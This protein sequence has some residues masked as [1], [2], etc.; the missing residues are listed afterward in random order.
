MASERLHVVPHDGNWAIK[1]ENKTSPEST[2]STQRDAI[3]AARELCKKDQAD[4]VIHRP[5]GTIRNVYSYTETSTSNMYDEEHAAGGTTT[6]RRDRPELNDLASVGS[7]ISWGAVMAGAF[8]AL[9]LLVALG[10][11]ATAAGLSVRDAVSDG[12]LF[13]GAMIC[14]IFALVAALFFG[15]FM[16]S[17]LTAGENKCEAATYGLVLW[18]T[19]FALLTL[20]TM[21]GANAGANLGNT[22]IL[23]ADRL[24]LTEEAGKQMGLDQEEI[25]RR[26][27]LAQENAPA[28]AWWTFGGVMLSMAAA[29]GGALLGAGP[30]L[31]LLRRRRD[32][33]TT[34]RVRAPGNVRVGATS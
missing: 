8:V 29:I 32:E 30:T 9:S 10:L 31:V 12:S 2:H 15:G 1:V 19:V 21:S 27:Q 17:V 5:D 22:A 11:L 24:G 13:V 18:G 4:L 7:R 14:S 23:G 33:R 3:D 16:T 6:E 20:L 28:A 25:A 26:R 34:V